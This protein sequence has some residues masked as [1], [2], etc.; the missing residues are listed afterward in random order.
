MKLDEMQ[1]LSL[2]FFIS[3]GA[4]AS[5]FFGMLL[6]AFEKILELMVLGYLFSSLQGKEA[7]SY[8]TW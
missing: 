5:F 2:H 8:E 3:S 4:L 7:N 6:K 1:S